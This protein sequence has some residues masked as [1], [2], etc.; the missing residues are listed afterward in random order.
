MLA[1]DTIVIFVVIRSPTPTPPRDCLPAMLCS[2]P[3]SQH[4]QG[5]RK[6]FQLSALLLPKVGDRDIPSDCGAF[7]NVRWNWERTPGRSAK[8]G[9]AE[10]LKDSGEVGEL[11]GDGG[12]KATGCDGHLI[13]LVRE[14]ISLPTHDP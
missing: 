8:R 4:L 10:R 3:F 7:R 11:A 12:A 9:Q 1:F 2:P 6:W 14:P 13:C 5:R